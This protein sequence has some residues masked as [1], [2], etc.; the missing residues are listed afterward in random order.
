MR[1]FHVNSGEFLLKFGNF[2]NS[3]EF[4]TNF[5]R[6]SREFRTNLEIPVKFDGSARDI[7]T[8]FV[9]ICQIRTN[10]VRISYDIPTKF[11]RISQIRAQRYQ[12]MIP[13]FFLGA[14]RA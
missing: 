8:N 2:G 4:R 11:V 10:F 12:D 14:V 5:V 7:R 3:Y 6:N 9:R 13:G 1:E